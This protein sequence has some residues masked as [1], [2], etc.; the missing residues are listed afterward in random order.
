MKRVPSTHYTPRKWNMFLSVSSEILAD[1]V[2]KCLLF[3]R[4]DFSIVNIVL[5]ARVGEKRKGELTVF[6][7]DP[8]FNFK[9]L[10]S[11]EGHIELL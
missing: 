10:F 7:F 8:V 3:L 5:F 9:I 11:I 1:A 2:R 4:R 6:S